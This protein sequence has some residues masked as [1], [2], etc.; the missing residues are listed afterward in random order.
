MLETQLWPVI[1]LK[2]F[3]TFDS[4]INPVDLS[5]ELLDHMRTSNI[6]L[7]DKVVLKF[8]F[9]DSNIGHNASC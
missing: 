3:K 1:A 7:Q 9:L 6:F 2:H 4:D 8:Y 5:I